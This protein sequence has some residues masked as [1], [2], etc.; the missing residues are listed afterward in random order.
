M[1][2]SRRSTACICR[3]VCGAATRVS[4]LF[5]ARWRLSLR[6][7]FGRELDEEREFLRRGILILDSVRIVESDKLYV[8]RPNA[9]AVGAN[10]TVFISDIAER[11]VV[12]VDGVGRVGILA[13]NGGGPGEVT[14][15]TSV[16]VVGDAIVVIKNTGRRRLEYFDART[17]QFR[18]GLLMN[19]PAASLSA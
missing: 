9:I 15:P 10:R 12:R 6:S 4:E 2:D 18:G 3:G 17:S 19:W 8:G 16:A 1:P 11:R 13:R 5:C 7:P 14:N